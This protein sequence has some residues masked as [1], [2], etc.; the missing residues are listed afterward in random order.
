MAIIVP[1]DDFS[2]IFVGD[3]GNPLSIQVLHKNGYKDL[4]GATVTMK[5]FNATT[6]TVKTCGPHWTIGSNGQASYAYQGADVDTAGSW[7][8]WIDVEIGGEPLHLDDGTGSGLPKI[9]VIKSL[10]L[11]V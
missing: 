9:L 8:M 4:S 3:T 10:P 5:L 7:E 2:P 11:G 1:I 6:N